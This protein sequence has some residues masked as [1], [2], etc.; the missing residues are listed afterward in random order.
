MYLDNTLLLAD[1]V[2]T[3]TSAASSSYIDTQAAS[4]DYEG[5]FF[6]VK[7]ETT[8]FTAAAGAPAVNFQLQTSD[9]TTFSGARTATF[10]LVQS[11]DLLAAELTASTIV[12]KVRI[13]PGARRYIRGYYYINN[14]N[15]NTAYFSACSY[16]MFVTPDVDLL[17]TGAQ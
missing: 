9:N 1:G 14:Y 10:T 11:A 17:I 15:A 6:V 5:S 4:N 13:P 12:Y 16:T 8:A 3:T 2:T 7:V